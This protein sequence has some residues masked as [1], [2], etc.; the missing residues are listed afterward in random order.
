M[1]LS[2]QKI[3]GIVLFI[4]SFG[5]ILAMQ[6]AEFIDGASYNV[7]NNYISDLGTFC[8]TSTTC[9]NLP[10]HNL[11]DVSVFLVGVAIAL[12]SY[13]L[14]RAFKDKIFSGLLIISGIGAMGVGTF[15]ENFPL[16]HGIFSLIVFLFGGFA[17][18]AAYRIERKPFGYFSALIGIFSVVMLLLYVENI[19]LGLGAGGMERIVAYPELL[20]GVGLGGH[21]ISWDAPQKEPVPASQR[22]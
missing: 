15:P 14:Y 10:S 13:Y 20:W 8:K 2:N 17:A 5:F 7:S 9:V 19:Y 4:G 12:G 11:F 22:S 3:A 6:V 1:Q 16:E 21:M 18:I